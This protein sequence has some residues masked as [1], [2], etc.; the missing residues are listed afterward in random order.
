M[1]KIHT[2]Q[3][4]NQTRAKLIC[5]KPL[6]WF[7]IILKIE[8]HFWT[9][10]LFVKRISSSILQTNPGKFAELY[11]IRYLQHSLKNCWFSLHLNVN[12]HHPKWIYQ[13]IPE[14][15]MVHWFFLFY[16]SKGR[17]WNIV[18]FLIFNLGM[19][20]F[21]LH[22][23]SLNSINIIRCNKHTACGWIWAHKDFEIEEMVVDVKIWSPC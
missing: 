22:M 20:Y 4:M 15:E 7:I 16:W 12:I 21:I 14:N 18:W 8:K 3:I 23:L 10:P 19:N 1:N 11:S 9:N 2:E 13:C 6:L 5:F 17:G